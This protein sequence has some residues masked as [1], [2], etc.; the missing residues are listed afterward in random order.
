ME[1]RSAR[2]SQAANAEGM[3]NVSESSVSVPLILP[4]QPANEEPSSGP[5]YVLVPSA[6]PVRTFT[7]DGEPTAERFVQEI[8]AA[9]RAGF[10]G[11]EDRAELLNNSLSPKVARGIRMRTSDRDPEVMLQV[12]LQIHGRNSKLPDL[13]TEFYQTKQGA[14]ESMD[15]FSH[16]LYAVYEKVVAM[17]AAQRV[18][19][20]G[21]EPLRE[22]FINQLHDEVAQMM[23]RE[24]V[25]QDPEISFLAIKEY[26][27]RLSGVKTHRVRVDAVE[28]RENVT[29]HEQLIRDQRTSQE[30][31]VMNAVSNPPKTTDNM[32]LANSDISNLRREMAQMRVE[33]AQL[34]N[35]R[36]PR[37]I[38]CHRCGG[39]GHLQRMCRRALN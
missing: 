32:A 29:F 18:P 35:A 28:G 38:R 26:S 2:A 11:A 16:R 14:R 23:L 39:E 12:L 7:G 1:T 34:R 27:D 22:Q 6:K 17:Q 25:L 36:T 30:E 31:F 15:D 9:W 33:L 37:V 4:A 8:R 10:M 3:P 21:D 13:L 19:L 5:R 24:R 20:M